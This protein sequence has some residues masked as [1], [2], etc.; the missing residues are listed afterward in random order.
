[1]TGSQMVCRAYILRGSTLLVVARHCYGASY[2]HDGRLVST[3]ISASP[4]VVCCC[5]RF[6]NDFEF[7]HLGY[8]YRPMTPRSS[9]VESSNRN[10]FFSVL[11]TSLSLSTCLYLGALL[12]D[13]A[14][15]LNA[16]RGEHAAAP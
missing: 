2:F 14:Q 8:P 1:M 16:Q 6:S 11:F 10:R 3:I 13:D 12:A 7:T 5:R 9:M 4:D 15:V